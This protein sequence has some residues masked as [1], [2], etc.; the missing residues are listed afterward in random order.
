VN[1]TCQ[2][3]SSADGN[4]FGLAQKVGDDDHFTVVA[5]DSFRQ[6]SLANTI[7]HAIVAETI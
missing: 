1:A 5:S 6:D 3:H 7:P 4:A 2:Y